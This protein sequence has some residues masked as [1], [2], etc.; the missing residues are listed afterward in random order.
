MRTG[1]DGEDQDWAS[2]RK[3]RRNPETGD[4]GNDALDV[5]ERVRQ[6]RWVG[7]VAGVTQSL[8]LECFQSRPHAVLSDIFG[9][10]QPQNL[11]GMLLN[12][13]CAVIAQSMRLTIDL[14]SGVLG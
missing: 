7:P 12:F 11:D 3:R 5:E 10:R 8:A 9:S 14:D 4:I 6:S 13:F 1:D 2:E